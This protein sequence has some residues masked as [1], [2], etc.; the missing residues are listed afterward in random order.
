MIDATR[1]LRGW[2]RYRLAVLDR[3]NAAEVQELQLKRLL[4]RASRTR[5]GREHR[6]DSISSMEEFQARVPLR[7]Y[8][9][10]WSRYWKPGFPVVRDATWPGTIPYFA[11]TSGTTTGT[12]KY[13]PVTHETL[14]AYRSAIL[15][16]LAFH[17]RARPQSRVL[18]GKNF[19]LGGSVDL[20]ELGTG[21]YA[22]DISGIA[23]REV[24]RWARPFYFPRGEAGEISDWD[25]KL[26]ILG[27]LSLKEDIRT[28][29]GTASWLLFFLQDLVEK[30]G[31][32]LS[33]CYPN[34][35]LIAYGG[36]NFAPY[37]SQYEELLAG[38]AVDL[39][40]VYPASEGFIAVADRGVG[41]GLRLVVDGGT[42][43]EF[44][45]VE[46]LG[47][48]NPRRH[49]V[50]N[51]ETGVNYGVVM[52]TPGGAWSYI[53]GDT[54]R[55]VDRD[56]PR[57]LVTGRTASSLSAFGE[58]L[59]EE[60]IVRAVAAAA[61][62]VGAAAADF[63]V[64]PVYPSGEDRRGFHLYVVEFEGGWP[65]PEQVERFAAHLDSCLRTINEDYDSHRR[66]DVQM[67]PP[68]VVAAPP[69]T[70]SAWMR[71]RGRLGGQNKVPRVL[72]DP[73]LLA[74]LRARAAR[75]G[76]FEA[77]ESIER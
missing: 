60:E 55:F 37:R 49:W 26:E 25:R 27:P 34:L 66:G 6:F 75:V 50:G 44:V 61:E 41:E 42:F 48:A 38:S 11:K 2:A 53:L 71:S 64:G 8:E 40:E 24:P 56:P 45:P 23:A 35:E 72:H 31:R 67:K 21:I 22:G 69:G 46:E 33:E 39:R 9:D 68:E 30:E 19:M 14:K 12:S 65:A 10:F 5:F 54:V 62:F 3:Q 76:D 20:D 73:E 28:I 77:S 4:H 63:S 52:S 57:L 47:S 32:S 36:V 17:L 29:G 74:E 58:H 59:I 70:F 51:L 15:D 16:M 18:G 43:F 7:R 13:I 1:F